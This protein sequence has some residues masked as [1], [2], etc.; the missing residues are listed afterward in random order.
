MEFSGQEM[1]WVAIPLSRGPTDPGIKPTSPVFQA[2][3]LQ[4][5]AP[6]KLLSTNM[7]ALNLPAFGLSKHLQVQLLFSS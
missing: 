7:S 4:S 3:P 5:E 2:D 1:E 6:G